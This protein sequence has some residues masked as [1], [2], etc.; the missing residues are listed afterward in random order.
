M[1]EGQ[2]VSRRVEGYGRTKH[3][4]AKVEH[5]AN[6]YVIEYEVAKPYVDDQGR[7]RYSGERERR[8]FADWSAAALFL[9]AY[10]EGS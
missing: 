9:S 2:D 4:N 10:F 8:V 7:T 5:V 6:G 3:R 1:D